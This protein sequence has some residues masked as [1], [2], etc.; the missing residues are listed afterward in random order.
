MVKTDSFL[1]TCST[2][3]PAFL[4]ATSMESALS[5]LSTSISRTV[6]RGSLE[7]ASKALTCV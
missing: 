2:L 7:I 6:P 1:V 3:C 5:G 4:T